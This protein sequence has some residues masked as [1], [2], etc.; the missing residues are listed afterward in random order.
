MM[1]AGMSY[2]EE[3]HW[4]EKETAGHTLHC[5]SVLVFLYTSDDDVCMCVCAIQSS[6]H[7]RPHGPMGSIDA[8][9]SRDMVFSVVKVD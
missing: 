4:N 6:L 1:A 9:P 5:L 7:C 8:P 3:R 2:C